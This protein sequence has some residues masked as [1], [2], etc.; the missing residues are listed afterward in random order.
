[1]VYTITVWLEDDIDSPPVMQTEIIVDEHLDKDIIDVVESNLR[2]AFEIMFNKLIVV[3]I[4]RS[5]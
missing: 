4:E 1:M 3:E 5:Y 2:T